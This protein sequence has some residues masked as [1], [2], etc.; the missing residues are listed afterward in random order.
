M[1]AQSAHGSEVVSSEGDRAEEQGGASESRADNDGSDGADDDEYDEEEEGDGA[2]YAGAHA[3]DHYQWVREQSAAARS[4]VPALDIGGM[5]ARGFAWPGASG[6]VA[7]HSAGSEA[8]IGAECSFRDGGGGGL[9]GDGARS[10]DRGE[11]G[12]AAAGVRAPFAIGSRLSTD[13]SGTRSI[14]PSSRSQPSI[15]GPHATFV[16][17]TPALFSLSQRQGSSS[18]SRTFVEQHQSVA[19]SSAAAAAIS[20]PSGVQERHH[21]RS[22][23]RSIAGSAA[24]GVPLL[25]TD[26]LFSGVAGESAG[27]DSGADD[28][29]GGAGD[30]QAAVAHILA[31][32]L[33]SEGQGHLS[34]TLQR[35]SRRLQALPMSPSASSAA[36]NDSGRSGRRHAAASHASDGW[37]DDHHH[38]APAQTSRPAIPAL[39]THAGGGLGLRLPLSLPPAS[40]PAA[41]LPLPSVESASGTEHRSRHS[42]RAA[43]R[44]FVSD[45]ATFA[46]LSR[47]EQLLQVRLF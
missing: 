18:L 36:S 4:L 27:S 37:M 24:G 33:E 2:L 11:D 17:A 40:L 12:V 22:I 1:C 31:G 16:T 9:S 45:A 30:A 32:M 5:T 42:N 41:S 23:T 47:A 46:D 19:T 8:V 10:S 26:A 20:I 21:R 29:T 13:T 25:S 44:S 3:S 35:G 14:E 15:D 39:Q 6:G 7:Q 34:S 28:A 38:S 43:R